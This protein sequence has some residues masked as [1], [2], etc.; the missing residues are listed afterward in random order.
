L[1]A[2]APTL[3]PSKLSATRRGEPTSNGSGL[4]ADALPTS[5]TKRIRSLTGS[6]GM[7]SHTQ[8]DSGERLA[9]LGVIEEGLGSTSFKI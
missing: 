6:D 2:S 4:D 8:Q 5:A 7:V 3:E 1:A 9:E